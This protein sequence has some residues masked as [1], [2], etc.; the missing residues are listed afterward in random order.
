MTG[1]NALHTDM[2]GLMGRLICLILC[3]GRASHEFSGRLLQ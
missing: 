1:A 2:K 3:A